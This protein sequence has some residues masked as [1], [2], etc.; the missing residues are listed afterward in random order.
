MPEHHFLCRA[1][2]ARLRDFVSLA[3]APPTLPLLHTFSH[4]AW[5]CRPQELDVPRHSGASITSKQ[6][7]AAST[8]PTVSKLCSSGIQVAITQEA[9]LRARAP[10][11]RADSATETPFQRHKHD[12][13]VAAA[14]TQFRR[15]T[16]DDATWR[17][18]DKVGEV[19]RGCDGS[20]GD[21][22]N[23]SKFANA[24]PPLVQGGS[25]MRSG[26]P[27][28]VIGSSITLCSNYNAPNVVNTPAK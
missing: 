9:W 21:I 2:P 27:S 12:P 3:L 11:R 25:S 16:H 18:G 24:S 7:A 22:R 14:E 13:D 10:S 6:S 17:P 20:V 23:D 28:S 5:P 1:L 26:W 19:L 4:H 15:R 8:V